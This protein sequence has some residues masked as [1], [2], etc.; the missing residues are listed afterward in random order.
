MASQPVSQSVMAFSPQIQSVQPSGSVTQWLRL[1][2]RSG[3][4]RSVVSPVGL[5]PGR[6]PC[7]A[8][9]PLNT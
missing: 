2:P 1:S 6:Y 9:H 5:V 3:R 7:E 4:M 8:P